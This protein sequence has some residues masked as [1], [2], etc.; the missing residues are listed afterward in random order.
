MKSSPNRV[1]P[2]R[3]S[4]STAP[5]EARTSTVSVSSSVMATATSR[6]TLNL[7]RR[8]PIRLVAKPGMATS[9][10]YPPPGRSTGKTARPPESVRTDVSGTNWTS[11]VRVTVAPGSALLSV[12]S[13]TTTRR[14]PDCDHTALHASVRTTATSNARALALI[15]SSPS[16]SPN[17]SS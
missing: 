12:A 1:V 14:P 9:T 17:A 15:G 7:T 5:V 10:A 6:V 2:R 8:S 4:R 16:T 13:T 11:L 3:S